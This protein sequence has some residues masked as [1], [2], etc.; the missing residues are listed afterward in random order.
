MM[1]RAVNETA[2]SL[3]FFLVVQHGLEI[4]NRLDVGD[5]GLVYHEFAAF[6]LADI[7]LDGWHPFQLF[8]LLISYYH[9]GYLRVNISNN[10]PAARNGG[11]IWRLLNVGQKFS[12]NSSQNLFLI[13]RIFVYRK[14][15]KLIVEKC[16]IPKCSFVEI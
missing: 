2:L 10:H 4:F 7:C 13:Q 12:L 3:S 9:L 15:L 6:G 1:E 8:K 14:R 11:I 5:G 16:E